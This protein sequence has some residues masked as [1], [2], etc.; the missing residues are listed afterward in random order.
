M[1]ITRGLQNG[2]P[3][4][5]RTSYCSLQNRVAKKICKIFASELG[6]KSRVMRGFQKCIALGYGT[7]GSAQ[8]VFGGGGGWVVS[9][10]IESPGP[11]WWL[12]S[13]GTP[14]GTPIAT[15]S[16]S[17]LQWVKFWK[18]K[19]SIFADQFMLITF[20]S[21]AET[22][23]SCSWVFY[24]YVAHLAL[25]EILTWLFPSPMYTLGVHTYCIKF[26]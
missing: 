11:F 3:L 23:D 5:G 20:V 12:I 1:G 13:W 16:M 18:L 14:E 15:I 17:Q 7:S 24:F 2:T 9:C 6:T 4:G 25:S 8:K 22:R 19:L 26:V 21:T 10:I